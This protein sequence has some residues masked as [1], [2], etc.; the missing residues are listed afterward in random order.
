[1]F[2]GA[3]LHHSGDI[4]LTCHSAGWQD[5]AALEEAFQDAAVDD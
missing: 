1:M 4:P 2:H 5:V 3:C